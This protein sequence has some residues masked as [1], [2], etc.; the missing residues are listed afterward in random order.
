[1]QRIRNSGTR[2]KS[3]V[4]KSGV[5]TRRWNDLPHNAGGASAAHCGGVKAIKEVCPETVV[6]AAE[7]GYNQAVVH[8]T[9]RQRYYC[10]LNGPLP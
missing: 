10:H 3:Q 4:P 8:K 7:V 1:M 5:C 2:D 6:Y 9:T